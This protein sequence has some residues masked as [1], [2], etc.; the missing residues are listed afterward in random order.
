MSLLLFTLAMAAAPPE[1]DIR[2]PH[3]TEAT[4][5]KADE[6]AIRSA[7][8]SYQAAIERLDPAGTERLFTADSAIFESGGVK[9]TYANYLAH[10]LRPELAEF[11]SFRFSEYRTDIR[12]EGPVA[13]ATETYTYRVETK[14]GEVAERRGVTT[15]VLKRVGGEWRIALLHSSARRP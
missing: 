10:P 9:G 11:R 3:E 6:A 12:F 14:S 2:Q 13:L 8:R 7:L 5:R 1:A 4:S 15:S